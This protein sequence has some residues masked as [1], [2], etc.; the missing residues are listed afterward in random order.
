MRYKF[1][2]IFSI[3][4]ISVFSYYYYRC[5][6][7]VVDAYGTEA[8]FNDKEYA[9]THGYRNDWAMFEFDLKQYL[10]FYREYHTEKL[11]YLK[12]SEI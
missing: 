11:L 9:E 4:V 6:L 3:F 1:S 5:H 7:R 2:E 8:M 12:I 10:T